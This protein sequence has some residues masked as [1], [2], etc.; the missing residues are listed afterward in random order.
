MQTISMQRDAGGSDE[1]V[2][3]EAKELFALP[4]EQFTERRNALA[5]ELKMSGRDDAATAVKAL[6]KPRVSA[7]AV[8]QLARDRT[9]DIRRLVE[10]TEELR[11]VESADRFR[12][13]SGERN[14]LVDALVEVAPSIIE[15]RGANATSG[16]L[17][18]LNQTLRAATT[19]EQLD[20]LQQGVVVEPF[21]ASGFGIVP[22]FE[23]EEQEQQPEKTDR[24][25]EELRERLEEA[26]AEVEDKERS[27]A[28]AKR[29]ADQAQHDLE[30]ARRTL[31]RLQERIERKQQANTGR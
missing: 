20:A 3:D 15:K 6:R 14:D 1:R 18:E 8:N 22:A 21:E 25:L 5:K 19:P 23:D 30:I 17:H 13:L 9:D 4:L 16:V 28:Q 26:R 11:S 29:R 27:A 12:E 7:W 10:V 24:E 31:E 2:P